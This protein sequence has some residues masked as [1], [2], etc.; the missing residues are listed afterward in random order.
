MTKIYLVWVLGLVRV[1][2]DTFMDN[3]NDLLLISLK[4]VQEFFGEEFIII[5]KL[6]LSINAHPP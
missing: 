3:I 1:K 6:P 4:M 5:L 2:L